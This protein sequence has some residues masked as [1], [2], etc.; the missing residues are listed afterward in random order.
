M[1]TANETAM[2]MEQFD[3]LPIPP[4]ETPALAEP[5][6]LEENPEPCCSPEIF[7][8]EAAQQE[9]ADNAPAAMTELMTAAKDADAKAREEEK[10][11]AAHEAAEAKRKE[12]WEAKQQAKK[13]AEEAIL[14]QI[15]SMPDDALIASSMKKIEEDTERLTRRNMKL[16]VMEWIQTKCLEDLAFARMAMHPKKSMVNCFHYINRMAKDYLMLEMEN[17]DQSPENGIYGGDVPDELCYQ[18]AEA[19]FQD[20]DAKE[21]GEEKEEF[22][23]RPYY[24]GTAKKSAKQ[25]KADKKTEKAALSK[26]E[27]AKENEEE[28]LPGQ[29]SLFDSVQEVSA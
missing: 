1:N 26:K 3:T 10:K 6:Q 14:M 12:D 27:A 16:C 25:K 23:P 17:D 29:L 18:W 21:D 15:A 13:A 4:G 8:D 22:V 20:P 24:G 2:E 28:N 5:F 19:Y 7:E 11:R 9:E